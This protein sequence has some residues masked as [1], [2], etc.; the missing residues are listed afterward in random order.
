MASRSYLS[1]IEDIAVEDKRT[2]AALN[3]IADSHEQRAAR[4]RMLLGMHEQQQQPEATTMLHHNES[5]QDATE[6][7]KQKQAPPP[8][9]S[10]V[11]SSTP[12]SH[13]SFPFRENKANSPQH[14]P[15]P[16]SAA[17]SKSAP[18]IKQA[19]TDMEEMYERLQALGLLV[20]RPTVDA[21]GT[22][23][24]LSNDMQVS[25]HQHPH[26]Q[27][28]HSKQYLSSDLGESF[29]LLPKQS[30]TGTNQMMAIRR[31]DGEAT[32]KAA[33]ASRMKTQRERYGSMNETYTII[34]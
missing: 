18:C 4:W 5:V 19:V 1:A 2:R 9:Q 14:T 7:E 16:S 30:S 33:A 31:I 8:P 20:G 27:P 32:L 34:S 23:S 12:T 3:M 28:Q 11:S 17:A 26:S 13:A 21:A 25:P 6:T 10:S 15:S 22:T 24:P 29:C